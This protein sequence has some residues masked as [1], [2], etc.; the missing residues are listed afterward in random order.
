MPIASKT[1]FLEHFSDNVW[2][3][4][5]TP[6]SY[7]WQKV[8]QIGTAT[9]DTRT[10]ANIGGAAYQWLA[11]YWA[12]CWYN[13]TADETGF[14][15]DKLCILDGEVSARFSMD[16]GADRA[17]LAFRICRGYKLGTNPGIP[18]YGY[19]FFFGPGTNHMT[20]YRTVN[21]TTV[22]LGNLDYSS[23]DRTDFRAKVVFK[24]ANI[25]T[26]IDDH[27]IHNYTDPT[28]ITYTG[29]YGFGAFNSEIWCNDF[30]AKIL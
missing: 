6:D 23:F 29:M 3:S 18:Y 9:L 16:F 27:L 30:H 17:F 13:P 4:G 2:A 12:T 8:D 11:T 5:M 21:G 25:K 7:G 26:Y 15:E 14:I 20:L 22:N 24:G 28:P 10:S 19:R 1:K